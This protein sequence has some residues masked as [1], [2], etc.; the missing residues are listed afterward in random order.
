MNMPVSNRT[1]SIRG[2]NSAGER[3]HSNSRGDLLFR[4]GR[5]D[6]ANAAPE[7]PILRKRRLSVQKWVRQ[8]LA[9]PE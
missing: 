9:I 7:R 8:V 2:R 6:A 3:D 5:A 1:A 4:W